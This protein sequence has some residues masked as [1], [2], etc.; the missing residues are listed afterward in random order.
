MDNE[1]DDQT[2]TST[3]D[4]EGTSNPPADDGQPAPAPAG[5]VAVDPAEWNRVNAE[6][7]RLRKQQEKA[8][9]AER[10]RKAQEDVEAAEAAGE[11]QKGVDA[12]N[13]RADDAE[14]KLA[15][16]EIRDA[17]RD[18]IGTLGLS[19]SKAAALLRLV[20]L[21]IVD[22]DAPESVEAAVGVVLQQYPDLF[23]GETT[24]SSDDT[25]KETRRMRRQPGPSSPPD[26]EKTTLPADYVSPEEYVA[27]PREVRYTDDFRARVAKSRPYWPKILP[28][29]TFAIEG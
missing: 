17:V 16:R 9:K 19:G 10:D 21:K 6:N 22:E 28:A 13:K 27:T 25:D 14:A 2:T 7:R 11:F 4:D 1:H 15:E 29:N 23:A 5:T 20:D 26:A 8:E 3:P 24:P 18:Y 12:A